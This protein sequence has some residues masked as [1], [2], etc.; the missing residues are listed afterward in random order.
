MGVLVPSSVVPVRHGAS[1]GLALLLVATTAALTTACDPP[2]SGLR[3]HND[4]SQAV[5]VLWCDDSACRHPLY[6]TV[7]Q[8]A[9]TTNASGHRFLV[10]ILD[11]SGSVRGC[12]K[13]ADTPDHPK[14]K[15]LAVSAAVPCPAV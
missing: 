3:V 15:I 5:K 2:L 13:W 10:K 6:P 4:T 7:L 8:P 12:I 14:S 9:G 11:R 1:L